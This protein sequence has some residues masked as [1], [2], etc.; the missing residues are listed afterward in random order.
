MPKTVT[1]KL[2]NPIVAH[3]G[4]KSEVILREPRGVDFIEL[5][6]PFCY[7]RADKGLVVH[8]ENDQAIK[9]YLERCIVEPDYLLVM[10]QATLRDMILIKENLFDFF[11]GARRDRSASTLNSLS[12]TSDGS[13][14][15]APAA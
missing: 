5:G 8:A 2:E 11:V 1:V 12:S 15:Q 6:E 14:P 4:Q 7:A 13:T 10:S 9:G 3:G